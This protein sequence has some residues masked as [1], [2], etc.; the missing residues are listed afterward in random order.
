MPSDLSAP[1][2]D[3]YVVLLRGINVG[4]RNRLPMHVL[5]RVLQEAGCA[6]VRTYLQSGQAVVRAEPEGLAE[7]VR[8]ALPID[9]VVLVRS[10]QELADVVAR[11][12]FP[13]RVQEPKRLHVAFLTSVPDPE[14]VAAL[15][16]R[17][18]ADRMVV[19]GREV[20]LAYGGGSQES[21]LTAALLERRLRVGASARNWTT[22]TTLAELSRG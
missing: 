1:A 14:A 3:T 17:H 22:V 9:V 7:R 21:T 4:G 5:T 15:G 11:N 16:P 20:Y 6:D 8:A 18:G 2:P 13:E 12:P 19:A 10:G